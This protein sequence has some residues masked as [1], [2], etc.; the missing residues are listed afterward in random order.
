MHTLVEL[1]VLLD[2]SSDSR[3]EIALVFHSVVARQLSIRAGVEVDHR[4]TAVDP[5]DHRVRAGLVERQREQRMRMLEAPG[6]GM[7]TERTLDA[8]VCER[9]WYRGTPVE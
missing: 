7:S 2:E 3:E 4:Q 9:H 8:D 5:L 1:V 6:E